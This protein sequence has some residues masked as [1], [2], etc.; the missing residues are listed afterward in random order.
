[1]LWLTYLVVSVRY[2]WPVKNLCKRALLFIFLLCWFCYTVLV[3]WTVWYIEKRIV[4]NNLKSKI[5]YILEIQNASCKFVNHHKVME[6]E[7]ISYHFIHNLPRNGVRL[8]RSLILHVLFLLA[9]IGIS[10]EDIDT[11]ENHTVADIDIEWTRQFII[12]LSYWIDL[13]QFYRHKK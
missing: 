1:M 9:F 2:D 8:K 6:S 5:V 4:F 10:S 12:S 3:V 11:C 13:R 7:L